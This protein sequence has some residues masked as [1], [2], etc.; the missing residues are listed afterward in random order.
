MPMP[1]PKSGPWKIDRNTQ[2]LGGAL[3]P[4]ERLDRENAQSLGGALDS[5]SGI[6]VRP[7]HFT[8]LQITLEA[9]NFK[10]TTRVNCDD[11]GEP[12]VL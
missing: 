12:E 4:N 1:H 3:D 10:T 8:V 11:K 9:D 5:P 7:F 2:S 6:E